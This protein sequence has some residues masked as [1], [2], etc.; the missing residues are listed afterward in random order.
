MNIEEVSIKAIKPYWRNPRNNEEG[1]EAVRKSIEEYGFNSPIIVDKEFVIIAGH[2]RYK[3]LQQ[4]GYETIPIIV[5]DLPAQKVKEYRIADNKTSEL[6]QWDYPKLVLELKELADLP[7]MQDFFPDLDLSSIVDTLPKSIAL[8]VSHADVTKSA[9]LMGKNYTSRNEEE[10]KGFIPMICPDCGY[11]YSLH[12]A[13]L[14]RMIDGIKK[15]IQ[16]DGGNAET[17]G[18]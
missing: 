18:E 16:Y 13:A 6:S 14:E 3:A 8:D 15:M 17:E 11:E 1:I 4:L 7:A 9:D 12:I 5:A 2:T 10:R